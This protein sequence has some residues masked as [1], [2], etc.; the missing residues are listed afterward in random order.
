MQPQINTHD[1]T[2]I[3][4]KLK[5]KNNMDDWLAENEV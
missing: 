4:F 3:F 2:N 5:Y 1:I